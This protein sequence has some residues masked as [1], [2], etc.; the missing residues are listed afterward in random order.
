VGNKSGFRKG[1]ATKDTIFKVTNE[2]LSALNNKTM[3]DSIFCELEKAFKS[4]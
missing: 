3:A 4:V 2:I 1:I